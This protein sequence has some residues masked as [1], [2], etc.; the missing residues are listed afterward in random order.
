M[1]ESDWSSDVCSSDLGTPPVVLVDLDFAVQNYGAVAL[2]VN[3]E[4]EGVDFVGFTR[5]GSHVGCLVGGDLPVEQRHFA[6]QPKGAAG[7]FEL[8]F[9]AVEDLPKR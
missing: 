3:H 7:L 4:F 9:G 6:A 5:A 1:R 8:V 2:D